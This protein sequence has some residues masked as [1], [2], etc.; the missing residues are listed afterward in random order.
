[1]E[2]LMEQIAVM[3]DKFRADTIKAFTDEISQ[4]RK[5]QRKLN[6]EVIMAN[7]PQTPYA[8]FT[9]YFNEAKVRIESKQTKKS[10]F[11]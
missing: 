3:F 8:E 4:A 7:L 2:H 9:K 6:M 5:E 1:M 11:K 10:F